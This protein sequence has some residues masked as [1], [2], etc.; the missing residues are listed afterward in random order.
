MRQDE[1]NK[2]LY[3]DSYETLRN[4]TVNYGHIQGPQAVY[5]PQKMSDYVAFRINSVNKKVWR[6]YNTLITEKSIMDLKGEVS[7]IASGYLQKAGRIIDLSDI[8]GTAKNLKY[9]STELKQETICFYKEIANSL[10]KAYYSLIW[11]YST[12]PDDSLNL[13]SIDDKNANE[14]S[15]SEGAR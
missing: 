12:Y 9:K 13:H 4:E 7:T 6:L 1:R 11:L 3:N 14:Y 2:E 15:S 5:K 10:K 8:N